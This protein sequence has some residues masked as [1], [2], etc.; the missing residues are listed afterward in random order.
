MTSIGFVNSAEI[1]GAT[2][3]A[4]KPAAYLGGAG[5]EREREREHRDTFCQSGRERDWQ[6]K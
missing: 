2:D 1:A 3:E 6:S 5:Q 4:T